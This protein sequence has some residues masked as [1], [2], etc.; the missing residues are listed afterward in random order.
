MDKV[1]VPS[2]HHAMIL[3]LP[4]RLTTAA[5]MTIKVYCHSEIN[6]HYSCQPARLTN[7]ASTTAAK[8]SCVSIILF[9]FLIK[10]SKL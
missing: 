2:F 3:Q 7:S 4:A 5:I 8:Q 6:T 1:L 9:L 10:L